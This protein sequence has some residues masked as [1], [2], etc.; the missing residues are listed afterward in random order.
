ME[1]KDKD[2]SKKAN[3]RGQT[4]VI[5]GLSKYKYGTSCLLNILE[6]MEVKSWYRMKDGSNFEASSIR[7]G[8]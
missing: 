5:K 7:G 3:R 2:R 8:S 4:I 6:T 1:D